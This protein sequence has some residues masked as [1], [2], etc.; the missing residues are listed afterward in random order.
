VA[1]LGRLGHEL[2]GGRDQLLPRALEVREHGPRR[3]EA[4]HAFHGRG[5]GGGRNGGLDNGELG[6]L[7]RNPGGGA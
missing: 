4:Q 3:V 5:L 6:R 2:V 7:E 1:V